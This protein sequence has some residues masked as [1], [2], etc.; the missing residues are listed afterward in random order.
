LGLPDKIV[1]LPAGKRHSFQFDHA[2]NWRRV[3]LQIENC[4]YAYTPPQEVVR[5]HV[6]DVYGVAVRDGGDGPHVV[7]MLGRLD[8]EGRFQQ[9]VLDELPVFPVEKTCRATSPS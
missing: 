5:R 7:L 4:D 1:L 2:L 6:R 3:V 8:S 9:E